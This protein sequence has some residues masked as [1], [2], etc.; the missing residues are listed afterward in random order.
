VC[1]DEEGGE[2]ERKEED[3]REESFENPYKKAARFNHASLTMRM[4]I[5]RYADI[6]P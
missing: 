2:R 5:R 4:K 1:E 6:F 3:G